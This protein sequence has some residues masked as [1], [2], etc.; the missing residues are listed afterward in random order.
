M[1][2]STKIKFPQEEHKPY[3]LKPKIKRRYERDYDNKDKRTWVLVSL[4]CTG[5]GR[6]V[7]IPRIPNLTKRQRDKLA[8]NM[9]KLPNLNENLDSRINEEDIDN[10]YLYTEKARQVERTKDV[11]PVIS[12]KEKRMR[13]NV[14]ELNGI[15]KKDE[16]DCPRLKGKINWDRK[17]VDRFLDCRPTIDE[18]RKL[19]LWPPL[20]RDSRKR[21]NKVR[22]W[23]PNPD[24]FGSLK[25]DHDTFK[26]SWNKAWDKERV[27]DDPDNL[28]EGEKIIIV[29]AKARKKYMESVI[30]K[31]LKSKIQIYQTVEDEIKIK[32][33]KKKKPIS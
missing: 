18:M 32:N 17:L 12:P 24:N 13:Q 10:E 2:H 30:K 33:R 31:H 27:L 16:K 5:C 14:K 1:T 6:I 23:I 8:K 15:Y 4:R 7:E 9:P 3:C 29:E 20:T 21:G 19:L 28:S 22:G 25:Y 11:Q 26:I